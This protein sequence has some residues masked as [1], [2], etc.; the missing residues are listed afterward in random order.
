MA[1]TKKWEQSENHGAAP[2]GMIISD[3]DGYFFIK[4]G[5]LYHDNRG[6]IRIYKRF[7]SDADAEAFLCRMMNMETPKKTRKADAQMN[8]AHK[9][10]HRPGKPK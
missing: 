10:A 2:I 3:S 1:H 9:K 4:H 6:K 8:E 7:Q 5:R